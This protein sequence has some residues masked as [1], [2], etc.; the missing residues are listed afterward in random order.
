M[1][2]T[3]T[4]YDPDLTDPITMPLILSDAYVSVSLSAMLN[5]PNTL[6]EDL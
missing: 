4:V 6:Y 5:N 1:I 2:M 3:V